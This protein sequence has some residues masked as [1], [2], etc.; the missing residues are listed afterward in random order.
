MRLRFGYSANRGLPLPLG[1][2]ALQTQKI[3]HDVGLQCSEGDWDHGLRPWS[4][5]GSDHGVG[6]DPEFAKIRIRII[7]CERPAKLMHP[8]RGVLPRGGLCGR[9]MRWRR[10]SD[11]GVHFLLIA[12]ESQRGSKHF[13][14][15]RFCSVLRTLLEGNSLWRNLLRTHF[16]CFRTLPPS[17]LT[18]FALPQPL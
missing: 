3:L 6:V 7:G 8:E 17:I 9:W 15:C 13:L 14:L 1:Q 16:L 4:R 12:A 5:K 18:P 2:G 10:W 11:E